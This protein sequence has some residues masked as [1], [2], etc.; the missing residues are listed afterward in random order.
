M[1]GADSISPITQIISPVNLQTISSIVQISA[2]AS[3]DLYIARVEL[4]KDGNYLA[5]SNSTVSPFAFN[6]DTTSE[7]IGNHTL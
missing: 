4:C 1:N 2:T 6:I 5:T 7:T 3:D